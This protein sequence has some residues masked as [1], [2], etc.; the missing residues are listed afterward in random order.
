VPSPNGGCIYPYP[1]FST[2]RSLLR[3][4]RRGQCNWRCYAAVQAAPSARSRAP[5]T[6]TGSRRCFVR[7]WQATARPRVSGSAA[8]SSATLIAST[9]IL[10]WPTLFGSQSP[11]LGTPGRY[12]FR[13]RS[14]PNGVAIWPPAPWPSLGSGRATSLWNGGAPSRLG[15]HDAEIQHPTNSA[16]RLADCTIPDC[17]FQAT[18][19]RKIVNFRE[20]ALKLCD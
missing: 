12:S 7:S 9:V 19:A 16:P 1:C 10:L 4:C 20:C 17:I 8:S 18:I 11:P 2:H 5:S 6:S 13:L 3:R 14:G 15:R